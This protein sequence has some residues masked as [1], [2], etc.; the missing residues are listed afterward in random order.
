[1]TAEPEHDHEPVKPEP[2]EIRTVIWQCADCGWLWPL[3]GKPPT[4]SECDN[5]GD[6]LIGML[7]G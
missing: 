6:D 2:V 3:P 1:M 7:A 5:C 4:G